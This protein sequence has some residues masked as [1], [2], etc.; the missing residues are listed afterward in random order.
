MERKSKVRELEG[1]LRKECVQASRTGGSEDSEE[2]SLRIYPRIAEPYFEQYVRGRARS[3]DPVSGAEVVY[4]PPSFFP[5]VRGG[6][7]LGMYDPLEH[8]IYI[9][10]NLPPEQRAFV[11]YHEVAHAL[12]IKSENLADAYAQ[13]KVGYN[14]RADSYP[15][16]TFSDYAKRLEEEFEY[17]GTRCAA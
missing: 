15:T 16:R 4:V 6:E 7:V 9:A 10:N 8:K 2:V 5:A 11:Y 3:V 17:R 14:I 12:G 13:S 1:V